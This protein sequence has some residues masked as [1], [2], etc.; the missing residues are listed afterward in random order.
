MTP[1]GR[2]GRLRPRHPP[3]CETI[4]AKDVAGNI[5]LRS[6]DVI[7]AIVQCLGA[8]QQR[9]LWY[10][11]K[12]C[13]LMV[14]ARL[15]NVDPRAWLAKVLSRIGDHPA[16]RLDELVPWNWRTSVPLP[17]PE[18]TAPRHS[19]DGLRFLHA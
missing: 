14:T 15:S 19:P 9:N 12:F 17:R 11:I 10:T 1:P 18:M 8:H 16:S 3:L 5:T 2:C 6:D 13:F 7:E 4:R